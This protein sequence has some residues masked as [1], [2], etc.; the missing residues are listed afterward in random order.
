MKKAS[1]LF[2]HDIHRCSWR[3]MVST[4]T[5]HHVSGI[6]IWQSMHQHSW[7]PC[8]LYIVVIFS[9][10]Y[11]TSLF[12][13]A[14]VLH[15]LTKL[16]KNRT[17]NLTEHSKKSASTSKTIYIGLTD[18]QVDN[19]KIQRCIN[20]EMLKHRNVPDTGTFRW[21]HKKSKKWFP[22]VEQRHWR[23]KYYESRKTNSKLS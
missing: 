19:A 16:T 3:F 15:C 5:N 9:S 20:T 17:R 11:A 1:N 22:R 13:W 23:L 8:I 12:Y 14:W 6:K 18:L 4:D 21:R 7:H 10:S 2:F